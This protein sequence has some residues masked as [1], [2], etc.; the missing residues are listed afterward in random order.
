MSCDNCTEMPQGDWKCL[1]CG[2]TKGTAPYIEW[3]YYRVEVRIIGKTPVE[4]YRHGPR[5]GEPKET[6]WEVTLYE[7]PTHVYDASI[8]GIP[9]ERSCEAVV[10]KPYDKLVEALET[11]G[12]TDVRVIVSAVGNNY[13]GLP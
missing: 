10:R 5:K 2:N 3:Q 1:Y 7:S 11:A 13:P 4:Y 8:Q 9:N 6:P 12:Y